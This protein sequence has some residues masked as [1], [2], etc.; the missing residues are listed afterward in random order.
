[1]NNGLVLLGAWIELFVL[2]AILIA[3]ASRGGR[4]RDRRPRTGQ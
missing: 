4:H 1:M 2:L 3:L